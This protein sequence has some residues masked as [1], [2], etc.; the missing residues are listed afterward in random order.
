MSSTITDPSTKKMS[1]V[2]SCP[3][4]LDEIEEDAQFTT[5]CGHIYCTKCIYQIHALY[6]TKMNCPLCRCEVTNI[7]EIKQK[8]IKQNLP[9]YDPNNY[10]ISP[11]FD[12][13]E[14][15]NSRNLFSNAYYTIERLEAWK[16]LHAFVVDE[17]TGF[18][19]TN[20]NEIREIMDEIANDYGNHSGYT[21][22]VTMRMMHFI[23]KYG[24]ITFR[25]KMQI[26][27]SFEDIM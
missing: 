11:S 26:R 20:S 14:C 1:D 4:C 9:E 19:F 21:M 16:K 27:R 15:N 5:S 3:V 10:P 7:S 24:W 25:E 18:C 6:I 22:G 12:F 23:A 17:N 2:L 13:I 8:R